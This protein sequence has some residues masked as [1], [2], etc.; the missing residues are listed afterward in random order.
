LNDGPFTSGFAK[1]S[2]SRVGKWLGWQIIRAYMENNEL[3]LEAMFAEK[4]SQKILQLS[5]YKPGK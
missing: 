5:K 2:P 3:G 4:D 1:E